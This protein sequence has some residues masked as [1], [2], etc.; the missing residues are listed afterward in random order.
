[1]KTRW[2]FG[3]MTRLGLTL[4]IAGSA[5]VSGH[6]LAF[7]PASTDTKAAA[8]APAK[9]VKIKLKDGKEVT[10]ELVAKTSDVVRIKAK[11][12]GADVVQDYLTD[13]IEEVT[14]LP[15]ATPAPDAKP[16]SKTETEN[17]AESDKKAEAADKATPAPAS[18]AAPATSEDA[19]NAHRVYYAE[20]KGEFGRNITQTLIRKL[21]AEANKE[22]ADTIIFSLDGAWDPQGESHFQGWRELL[23]FE[24]IAPAITDEI[25]RDFAKR[26]RVAIWVHQAMGG[27]SLI[28]LCIK[29]IYMAEDGKIGGLA[30]LDYMMQGNRTVVEKQRSLR[31][32]HAAGWV[33]KGGYDTRI[34]YA[35][36]VVDYILSYRFVGDQVEFLERLP[37]GPT[38]VLLT[39]AGPD[40]MADMIRGKG[41]AY[42]NI[43]A[44]IGRAIKI[45]R[46]TV[47]TKEDLFSAMGLDRNRTDVGTAKKICEQ[48]DRRVAAAE[49][50][51]QKL[52]NEDYRQTQVTGTFEQRRSARGKQ[53]RALQQM[54]ERLNS[55]EMKEIFD[56]GF[57]QEF[58][59]PQDSDLQSLIDKIDLDQQRDKK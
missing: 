29:E 21:T 30:G 46:G 39:D 36:A 57:R 45:S 10:G 19:A 12:N 51:L 4:A 18:N 31:L 54:L 15:N 22:N 38:E 37:D 11:V 3:S 7:E 50:E 26:P 55:K 17:K 56:D 59:I 58:R 42:L 28:P 35:M 9:M 24:D 33:I 23:R 32:Q 1:M 6:A 47:N 27:A 13:Q 8:K 5:M 14:D 43:N 34:M 49:K 41:K 48:W 53:K 16:E 40:T 25:E 20:L 2:A 52:W 44:E